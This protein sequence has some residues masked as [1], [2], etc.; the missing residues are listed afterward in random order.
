MTP[1][2]IKQTLERHEK[3]L[4]RIGDDVKQLKKDDPVF[5]EE[6]RP[7][8][9]KKFHKNLGYLVFLIVGSVSFSIYFLANP[10]N[11]PLYLAMAAGLLGSA[12][13]AMMSC[14]DRHA[15]GFEGSNGGQTP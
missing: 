2:D 10:P 15:N 1:D 5:K 12:I 4:K 9:E 11:L 7:D 14:L 6:E 8:L 3:E 13:A